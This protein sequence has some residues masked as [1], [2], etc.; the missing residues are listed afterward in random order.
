MLND[1]VPQVERFEV[2]LL[3][4]CDGQ[5]G[6]Q[7]VQLSGVIECDGGVVEREAPVLA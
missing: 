1:R 3:E 5:V 4:N 7:E 6:Q 2:R